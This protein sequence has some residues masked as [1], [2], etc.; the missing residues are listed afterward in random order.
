MIPERLRISGIRDYGPTEMNLG[1]ADEHILI[2][3]PNGA[4]KSTISFCMGAV[5]RSSKVDIEGLKSQNLPE[6]ETWRA[7]IHFLFKNEGAS[8]IDAP[9]FI[10]FRLICEQLPKQPIKL[11]YEIHDGDEIEELAL[12][13]TYRS[14]DANKNNF[15]A[16]RRELQYK[17]KIHPDLYYL[18][19]YQQEVNQFSVMA[20][21][22]RFRI[23]SEMHGI[24]RIQK[25][26]E[27][28]LEVV[29]DAREAF[30]DAT[31]KQKGYEFELNVARDHKER[32]E[33]N[34][35]RIN[36][37]GFQYAL[38]TNELLRNAEKTRLEMER[39]IEERRIELDELTDKE[40]M[41]TSHLEEAN[42][43][44][45][46]LLQN[47]KSYNEEL[48][49]AE[50]ALTEKEA[51]LTEV[52]LEVDAL[53]EE[54]S[55]LQ[56]AYTKLPFPEN[57]TRHRWETA[58]EQVATL[59]GKE[60][61]IRARVQ[62]SEEEIEGNRQEQSKIQADIDQWENQSKDAIELLG[63]YTSSYQLKN[64]VSELEDSLQSDRALRAE[65]RERLQ[66]C[67]EELTMLQRNQIESPR[68][69]AA[70]R[71]LKRQGIQAYTLR[72]FVKLMDNISIEKESLYDAIKYSIFYDASTCQPF[73]DLYHVSLKKLIPTRS[74]T[75]L[76]Q[77]GLT[78]QEGLSS[79]EK[80]D[81]ARVLWWIEQFFSKE[82]PFLQNGLLFDSRGSRGPEERDTYILS[83]KALEERQSIL[84]RKIEKFSKEFDLLTKKI[85]KE[86]ERY[87]LWNAD[88]HKVEE[89]EAL[90]SKKVEQQY[91]LEQ[92]DRLTEQL[93]LLQDS[94]R[95][96]EKEAQDVWKQ[97]YEEGEEVKAREADLLIYEQFGQQADK[98]EHLQRL[99]QESIMN[100]QDISK[101]KRALNSIQD[102]LD[103][104][105]GQSRENQ[106]DIESIEDKLN[107]IKRVEGQIIDQIHEKEDERIAVSNI[108]MGYKTELEELRLLIPD[109]VERAI[110]EEE[111][112]DSKFDLQHRQNQAKVEF[113]NALNEKNIDPNAVENYFTLEEEVTRKQDELQS[114]KNLLE[115]NEER[116]VLN[117]QRLETA[118]AMQVQRIN[119]LF[120]EYMGMFQFEGQIKYEKMMDK[121]GRPIFKLFIHV[122]KEGHRGKLV[123]VSLK[124]RGGRV[125]KGVSGGEESLSS[126]LFALSLLQNLENQAGFIV[127]D[128]FDSALDDT[129]KTKVFELYEEKLARKLI[130]LSPKAHENEYYEQFRKA[131]V[132]SHDPAQLKSVI[133]G[134]EMK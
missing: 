132:V 117:E 125:G 112:T 32:F 101:L 85:T 103:D 118:I 24:D 50:H 4:G 15:T 36:D 98:I 33:D 66:I 8:R 128:E 75:S 69:Q 38:T 104:L 6:D 110:A 99:E 42:E 114:A 95:E 5:L 57:E 56:E 74:I 97:A 35:R 22:E 14:G 87:R 134:L 129:R 106:R 18:I 130:I 28:S 131:F 109:L 37:N 71:H 11:Q 127:L 115:E 54:L 48:I 52:N 90:L 12:R 121:Q 72:H 40:N 26:W 124:A 102:K 21:E 9:P 55:E 92:L 17:Y 41:I 120:G 31:I 89:A 123:D 27:T 78:M 96:F 68:Q 122:R 47:Q 116:A 79:N 63:R 46:V 81:A 119:L 100:K 20:P 25:D 53:K 2:T 105:H 83:K 34:K 43:R 108:G 93:K 61:A 126:L 29:K 60:H 70:I 94:K 23:F 59:Q 65:L 76:P 51:K 45:V 84:E 82:A 44:Q 88:V 86:N 107:Q 111:R 62:R 67:K 77:Y 13:Q 30:N 19:W 91:R 3:G 49:T 16:Y 10:E 64:R 113:Q 80:N 133:R 73:N 1:N 39:Y 58:V 7:A